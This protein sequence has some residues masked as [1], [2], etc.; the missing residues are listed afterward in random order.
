MY[1]AKQVQSSLLLGNDGSAAT[2]GYRAWSLFDDVESLKEVGRRTPG[3]TKVVGVAY[4]VAEK[5]LIITIA[6]PD[7]IIR[8]FN[9]DGLEEIPSGQNKALGDWSALC[10]W[11]SPDSGSQYFY[12]FG[13]KQAMQF[14]IREKNSEFEIL[15]VNFL[16]PRE[17]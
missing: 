10:T 3:R 17:F 16:C 9:I 11:R 7:S 1:Y 14:V 4:G 13:K 5:K 12:L 2:G 8:L 15:E 6:A